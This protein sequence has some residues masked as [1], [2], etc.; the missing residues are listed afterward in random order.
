MMCGDAH[1][2]FCAGFPLESCSHCDLPYLTRRK[3]HLPSRIRRRGA[4]GQPPPSRPIPRQTWSHGRP[5]SPA[6]GFTLDPVKLGQK[7][8]RALDDLAGSAGLDTTAAAN[9]WSDPVSLGRKSRKAFDAAWSAI[10]GLSRVGGSGSA[11]LNSMDAIDDLDLGTTMDDTFSK[12]KGKTVLVIGAAG[13]IGQVL[14]RKLLLRGYN[15]RALLKPGSTEDEEEQQNAL[16]DKVEAYYG[17]VS[18]YAAVRAAVQG[19]DKVVYCAGV[20]TSFTAE[21][22]NIYVVG[23]RTVLDAL[24]DANNDNKQRNSAS[25]WPASGVPSKL[26][27]VNFG[28]KGKTGEAARENW[29]LEYV[30]LSASASQLQKA[31][32]RSQDYASVTFPEERDGEKAELGAE[33]GRAGVR[34][35]GRSAGADGGA[36]AGTGRIKSMRFSGTMYSRGSVAVAGGH[37]GKGALAGTEAINLRVGGDGQQYVCAVTTADGE[38]FVQRFFAPARYSDVRLPWSFF[39]PEGVIGGEGYEERRLR[40]EDI[41]RVAVRFEPRIG[42]A[43]AVE[44]ENANQQTFC[45]NISRIKASLARP[46]TDFVLVSRASVAANGQTPEDAVREKTIREEGE[47]MTRISGVGYTII[48][49]GPLTEA[50]GGYKALVFDQGDRIE[51]SVSAADV[52]DVCL[53]S[54]SCPE[55]RNKTFEVCD[56]Y[57][58][59]GGLYELVAHLPDRDNNYLGPALATL[60]SNT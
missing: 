51:Q 16:P 32:Y 42:M 18:D 3:P 24:A 29:K 5:L 28:A 54:L 7:S 6:D 34:K 47:T 31:M 14:V 11:V 45:L 27:V 1:T 17:D 33:E 50:P 15:V 59:Q 58:P 49:P 37:V 40:A 8:R 4:P 22:K 2:S 55:A 13:R 38:T 9:E 36:G 53:R 35:L 10:A 48:R 44:D 46:E 56:E 52:A 20:R 26:P 39:R 30:G 12:S 41:E 43:Q 21:L 57:S 25:A 23:V 19:A 60:E